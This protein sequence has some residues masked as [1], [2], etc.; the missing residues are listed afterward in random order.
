MNADT[1]HTINSALALRLISD[2]KGGISQ[3]LNQHGAGL[4]A[5]RWLGPQA[6]TDH[7][8]VPH[9]RI[10]QTHPRHAF[11]AA[12]LPQA[13]NELSNLARD[14]GS[15]THTFTAKMDALRPV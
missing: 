12:A 10:S 2:N 15:F 7:P 5:G 14:A 6:S 3:D 8:P 4:K 13:E 11:G 1:E 9:A